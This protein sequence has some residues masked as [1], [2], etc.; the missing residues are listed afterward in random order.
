[1]KVW[2]RAWLKPLSTAFMGFTQT[3]RV[4]SQKTVTLM[5]T[6]EQVD[7]TLGLP[8]QDAHT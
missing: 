4:V 1:M 2:E 7:K 5:R 3:V 6:K 8:T